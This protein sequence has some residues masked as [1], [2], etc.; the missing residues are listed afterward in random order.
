MVCPWFWQLLAD[1]VWRANPMQYAVAAYMD[2]EKRIRL[3]TER[4]KF[5]AMHEMGM[6]IGCCFGHFGSFEGRF[7]GCGHLN[8]LVLDRKE[9]E[10]ERSRHESM[11][12]YG[13]K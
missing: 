11:P 10:E 13:L 2:V 3:R 6:K 7:R 5:A 12:R 8:R 9:L 4:R 1:E